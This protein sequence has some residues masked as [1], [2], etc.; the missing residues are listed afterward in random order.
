MDTLE[1]FEV[2]Y[3]MEGGSLEKMPDLFNFSSNLL[4]DKILIFGGMMGSY[5]QSKNL[6]CIQLE[7]L[8]TNYTQKDQNQNQIELMQLYD[9][10]DDFDYASQDDNK[11]ILK[12]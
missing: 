3:K 1:W 12:K 11:G 5:S 10:D 7:H 4:D 2:K 8:R 9:H 6:Y